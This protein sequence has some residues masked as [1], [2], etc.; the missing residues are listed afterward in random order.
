[1][2]DLMT[3]PLVTLLS[4]QPLALLD[5]LGR[6]VA[7]EPKS[8]AT[9]R[10]LAECDRDDAMARVLG[11]LIAM[12][13]EDPRSAG[14]RELLDR[15]RVWHGALV[16]RLAARRSFVRR[17]QEYAPAMGMTPDELLDDPYVQAIAD[18]PEEEHARA[19]EEARI[20][21]EA[22]GGDVLAEIHAWRA[23]THPLH[24]TRRATA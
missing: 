16:E 18:L 21:R 5:A 19:R 20:A 8:L 11:D 4:S 2:V 23:G 1:M 9:A 13:A 12:V 6:L 17:A 14:E 7:A 15:A 22:F 24:P 3:A 10:S